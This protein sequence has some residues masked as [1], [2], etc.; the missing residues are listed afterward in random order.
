LPFFG[1]RANNL[2]RKPTPTNSNSTEAE[3]SGLNYF[4][5]R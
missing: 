1:I 2:A 4:F 5:Q 3:F